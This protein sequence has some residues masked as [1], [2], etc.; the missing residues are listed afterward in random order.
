[1]HRS[2]SYLSKC[3][4]GNQPY[5]SK[6][7]RTFHGEIVDFAILQIYSGMWSNVC[8]SEYTEEMLRIKTEKGQ[9]KNLKR[10]ELLSGE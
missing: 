8:E 5:I 1:M 2:Y 6:L 9:G 4:M 3:V 10:T 7:K